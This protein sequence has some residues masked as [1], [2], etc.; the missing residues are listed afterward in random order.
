MRVRGIT[1]FVLTV[2]IIGVVFVASPLAAAAPRIAL[3]VGNSNYVETP[4]ANPVND[5]RLVAATL[6]SLGFEVDLRLDAIRRP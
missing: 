4:L 3:V 1:R 5:A 2:I 6:R